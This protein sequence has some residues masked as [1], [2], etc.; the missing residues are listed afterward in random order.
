VRKKKTGQIPGQQAK[1]GGAKPTLVKTF[2]QRAKGPK[3][4]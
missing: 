1:S 2:A 4:Y 3:L